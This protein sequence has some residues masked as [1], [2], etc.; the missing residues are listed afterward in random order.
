MNGNVI[1]LE[2]K[3]RLCETKRA[4]GAG[5]ILFVL[6]L[7][8]CFPDLP[9]LARGEVVE[10]YPHDADAFT[11]GLVF[12]GSTL[13]ESTGLYGHSSLRRV[14]LETGDVEQTYQLPA[15]FFGEGIT[16]VDDRIIQVTWRSGTGFVYD[17]DTFEVKRSF[18]YDGE[19]WGLTTDGKRVIMSDGTSWLR[20]LDSETLSETERIQVLDKGKPVERLNEL[21]WVHGEIWA[22]IW[23]EPRI[24]RVDPETG[25]VLGWIDFTSLKQ[26]EPAGVLN[27]IAVKGRK[28]FV[29]GKN[30]SHIYRVTFVSAELYIKHPS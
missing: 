2:Q 13:Y 3:N 1:F 15:Q 17:K 9:Y 12:D 25:Q 8:S 21:E 18:T 29:T 30:W 19:G 5:A 22:N 27:G 20:L 28:V 10:T 11:Q 16:V 14:D 4:L 24:A 23:Q 26:Q 6:L 7:S